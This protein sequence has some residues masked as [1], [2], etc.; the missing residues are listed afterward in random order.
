MKER[1]FRASNPWPGDSLGLRAQM[2]VVIPRT[3]PLRKG[4]VAE[5][6]EPE[7]L[8][9]RCPACSE[10][11]VIGHGR[12]DKEAHDAQHTIICV[13][14]GQCKQCRKTITVLPA[15]SLPYTHYSLAARLEALRRYTEDQAPL[16]QAAPATE[17]A[18]RV[19]A[20]PTLRRWFQRRLQ[21]WMH[22]LHAAAIS[23][24]TILAWDWRQ[25]AVF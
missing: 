9:R 13:R 8:P 12:R 11:A 5:A 4:G 3:S 24:T 22:C 19:A 23:A 21:S 14:R 15:W 2:I 10:W 16:E 25:P 17:D 1:R 20:P 7:W 6:Y 18:D